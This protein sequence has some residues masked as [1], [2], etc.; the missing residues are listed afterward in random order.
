MCS[1]VIFATRPHNTFWKGIGKVLEG[2]LKKGVDCI[3]RM[4]LY[5]SFLTPCVFSDLLD[6]DAEDIEMRNVLDEV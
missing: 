2:L 6:L 4:L 3:I 1:D 5:T